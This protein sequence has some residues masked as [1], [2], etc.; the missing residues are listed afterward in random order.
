MT[1]SGIINV[2]SEEEC[3]SNWVCELDSESKNTGWQID[4]NGCESPKYNLTKCPIGIV[5][6][7]ESNVLMY[8]LP[9]GLGIGLLAMKVLKKK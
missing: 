1:C 4:L 8:I 6:P 9:I 5:S 7:E 3:I 2:I